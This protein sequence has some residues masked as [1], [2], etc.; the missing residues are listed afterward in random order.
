M[1]CSVTNA[2]CNSLFSVLF[3]FSTAFSTPFPEVAL[4]IAIAQFGGFVRTGART[5]RYGSTADVSG[6]GPYIHF[7]GRVSA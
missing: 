5:T 4:L 6:I 3:T 7:D 1:A 2:P